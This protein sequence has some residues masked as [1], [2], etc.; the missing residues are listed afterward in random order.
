MKVGSANDNDTVSSA[1]KMGS[2]T[3]YDVV[4]SVWKMGWALVMMK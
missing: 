3:G 4:R 2:G 1:W